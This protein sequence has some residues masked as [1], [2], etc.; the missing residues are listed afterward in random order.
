MSI[1]LLFEKVLPFWVPN[2][3]TF[4]RWTYEYCRTSFSIVSDSVRLPSSLHLQP[5]IK[6]ENTINISCLFSN[7]LNQY[8]CIIKVIQVLRQDLDHLNNRL[9]IIRILT[10]LGMKLLGSSS[11]HCST[12]SFPSSRPYFFIMIF[13]EIFAGLALPS[14]I[15]WKMGVRY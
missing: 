6:L 2:P 3:S 8:Y 1:T 9:F 10:Q 11:V 7:V 15:S 5:P 13:R 4:P 14:Y 12:Y